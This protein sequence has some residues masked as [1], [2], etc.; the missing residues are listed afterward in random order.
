MCKY[1]KNGDECP[2]GQK[3]RFPCYKNY[4]KEE[5]SDKQNRTETNIQNIQE[6]NIKENNVTISNEE[7][8]IFLWEKMQQM[9]AE[10][11]QIIVQQE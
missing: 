5:K 2:F 3:C 9:V 10:N 4:K 7:N 1:Y 6:N 11:N 8:V